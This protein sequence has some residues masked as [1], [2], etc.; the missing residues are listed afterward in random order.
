MKYNNLEY[1]MQVL[2]LRP[3]RHSADLLLHITLK[4]ACSIMSCII[5]LLFLYTSTKWRLLS[6]HALV[7][8]KNDG[9]KYTP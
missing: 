8:S 9:M 5:F 7:H 2:P 3:V 4:Y 1:N 6:L